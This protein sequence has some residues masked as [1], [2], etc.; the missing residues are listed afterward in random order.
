MKKSTSLVSALI[1]LAIFH[2]TACS[3]QYSDVKS[4]LNKQITIFEDYI[5]AMNKVGNADDMAEAINAFS[6]DMSKII[7]ELKT[8]AEKYPE[9]ENNT[10]P[11]EELKEEYDKIKTFS[12]KVSTAMMQKFK[13]LSNPKVQKAIQEQGRIMSESIKQE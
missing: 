11:P 13:Y 7:P 6:K 10:T 3:S 8:I 4:T 2:L 9:L 1:L 12:E 5:N